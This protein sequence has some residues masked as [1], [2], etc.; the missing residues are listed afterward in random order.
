MFQDS[1]E[2]E[3][4]M[5]G[6]GKIKQKV[7]T[8]KIREDWPSTSVA[9]SN[10]LKFEMMMKTIEKMTDRMTVDNRSL[11]REQHEPQIRNPNFRR[12][13]PPPPPQIR[14][15]DIGNPRNPNDQ[16]I[17]PPFPE[18]YVDDEGQVEPIE[19]QIHHLD[20][21]DS[22]IYLTEEEHNMYAEEDGNKV[23]EEVLEKYQ[24]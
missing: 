7:E 1:L 14:Q 2:V 9:S 21:S 12:K 16:Q 3:V 6:S 22:E 20:D 5:M 15:R 11:N 10:D 23:C 4:N 18:N 8:R 19:D 24:R 13:N 17:Q